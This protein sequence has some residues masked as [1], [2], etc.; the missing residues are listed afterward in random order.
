MSLRDRAGQEVASGL[1][2]RAGGD[3]RFAGQ[4]RK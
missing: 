3:F 4:S 2:A 1:Q